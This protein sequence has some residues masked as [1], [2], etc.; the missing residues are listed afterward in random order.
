M[1]MKKIYKS[2]EMIV[3]AISAV[4]MKAASKPVDLGGAGDYEEGGELSGA[5]R[6]RSEWD[7]EE[8]EDEEDF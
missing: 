7:D 8:F 3:V 1:I 2:P 6:R 4:T 5:R